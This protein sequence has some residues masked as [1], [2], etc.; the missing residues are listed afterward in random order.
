[1]SE[2]FVDEHTLVEKIGRTKVRAVY[3][4]YVTVVHSPT[5]G[6]SFPSKKKEQAAA[7]QSAKK[8]PC[9]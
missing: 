3:L 4:A 6:G 7:L 5:M 1:M 8:G 2:A 9:A